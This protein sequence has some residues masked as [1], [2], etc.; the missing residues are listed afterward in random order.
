MIFYFSGTGN[1]RYVAR[2]LSEILGSDIVCISEC[3]SNNDFEDNDGSVGF[4]FPVYSWGVPPEVL[5]FIDNLPESFF[6]NIN[7]RHTPVWCV[8]T[9]GDEVALAPEMFRQAFSRH[10]VEVESIWSVTMPNNYVLL[11]GFDVDPKEVERRKLAEA[12]TRISEIAEGILQHRKT[13]DVV[14]GGSAWIKTKMVYPLFKRW[15]IFPKKW[16]STSSCVGCGICVGNCPN[17]NVRMVDGM[18]VWGADC[19][20]CLACY[21]SCPRHAVEYG[22]VTKKKGQYFFPKH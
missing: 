14:R 15:G 16:H 20:S 10:G 18:P 12:P 5:S 17:G 7:V 11:P 19:C 4:V 1:S 21:H 9:C 13:V 2:V 22:S 3:E 6:H 8:M